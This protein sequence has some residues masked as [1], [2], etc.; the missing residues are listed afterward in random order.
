MNTG[1]RDDTLLQQ[2]LRALAGDRQPPGDLWPDIA[3]ALP[4]RATAPPPQRPPMAPAPGGAWRWWSGA[5][6]AAGIALALL[7]LRMWPVHPDP[8]AVLVDTMPKA[9]P[10]QALIDAYAGVLDLARS[11]DMEAWLLSRPGGG[12][13]MAAARELDASMAGLAAAL[14]VEP[15][16]QLLRRLMHRTLQQRI[17]MM[18]R[19]DV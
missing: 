9:D 3:A 11:A 7:L 17:G 14:R 4:A 15:E 19:L 2:R 16:S 18:R 1:H 12:E 10:A 13:R 8:A 5:A 6:L